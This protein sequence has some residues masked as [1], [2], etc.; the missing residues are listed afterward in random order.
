MEV[1]VDD[2]KIDFLLISEHWL[3]K[4][5]LEVCVIENM[6]LVSSFCRVQRRGGGVCIYSRFNISDNCKKLPCLSKFCVECILEC[7]GVEI[8]CLNLILIVIYRVPNSDFNIFLQKMNELLE[9][10]CYGNKT[11]VIGGDYN[12]N[13]L[14]HDKQTS[15][16]L[17]LI[18]SFN[19]NIL[20]QEPTRV[21]P[22]SQTCIDNF[23]T[24][25]MENRVSKLNIVK[26]HLSDHHGQ[27]L[28]LE[29]K[30]TIKN[31]K[32]IEVRNMCGENVDRFIGRLKTETWTTVLSEGTTNGAF[33]KFA[34]IIQTYFLK[35]FPMR[36]VV[37]KPKNSLKLTPDLVELKRHLSLV[38]DLSKKYPIFRESFAKL[39]QKYNYEL[40]KLKRKQ[41]ANEIGRSDNK[42][43]TMW[44]L[45]NKNLGRDTRDGSRIKIK[46][47]GVCLDSRETSHAFNSY[48]S[49]T[50]NKSV[51]S[52]ASV[53]S[54]TYLID[55]RFSILESFFLHPVTTNDVECAIKKL[56]NSHSSGYDCIS[57]SLLKAMSQYVS[58]P[59]SHII[60][61]SFSEGIFP[62]ALK[63]AKIIP[64]FKKGCHESMENYRPISLISSFSKIIESTVNSFLLTYLSVHGVFQPFQHGFL[65]GRDV[66]TAL[67][68][69]LNTVI[70][71]YD[72]RNACI[73][74]FI[75]FRKAFDYVDR[76]ILLD[77]LETYGVRGV[78]LQWFKSYLSGRTQYVEVC[79][80]VSSV[81]N[82]DTGVPQGS[83]LGPTL[84][85]IYIN[86]LA[87]CFDNYDSNITLINYADDTNILI[88]GE[89]ENTVIAKAKE[90]LLRIH[91]WSADNKLYINEDKTNIIVYFK[92]EGLKNKITSELPSLTVSPSATMLGLIIDD[93]LTWDPHV[94]NLCTKLARANFA[95]R[96][97][98]KFC[99]LDMLR[100]LY[101]ACF[102]SILRYGIVHWGRVGGLQR[103][104]ILQKRAIRTLTGMR[105]RDSCREVFK[106]L[107]IMTA[108]SL[109]IYELL[110]FAYNNKNR[111]LLSEHMYDTR[112]RV[113]TLLPSQHRSAKFQ[114]QSHYNAC[115]IYNHLPDRFKSITVFSRFKSAV[116]D[117]LIN[118]EFYTVE[119]Y[120]ESC[121]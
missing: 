106:N 87:F 25:L 96:S 2:L 119:E 4:E 92:H 49:S 11:I 84:F 8:A 109:Y 54:S 12:L 118:N 9:E 101:F 80:A 95:L 50:A 68:E 66:N 55:T 86:D 112:H 19:C 104:F 57:N 89:S 83:I 64:V 10:V 102:H 74:L 77:K 7:C 75:D 28:T 78:A 105:P 59:L 79:G 58:T 35:C 121:S 110:C 76:K 45:I 53:Q 61:I 98:A 108:P 23:V 15:S 120:L 33:S 94:N 48:F 67:D 22:R 60:N 18:H 3:T 88:T 71:S 6:N 90:T 103:V 91:Q 27:L 21:T 43:K 93:N 69:Y 97:L 51:S 81:L 31:D 115:K 40:N 29:L 14:I 63:L 5:Y 72:K 26:T 24:N 116:R 13:F 39:N 113:N 20:F 47:N 65:R 100:T 85:L 44:K 16:F 62:E 17:D 73:G 70:T 34:E 56:K 107:G 36:K 52:Q 46:Q 1:L 30:N 99:S 41:I 38:A 82:S 117:Y 111:F 32:Y 114:R 37:S 42:T